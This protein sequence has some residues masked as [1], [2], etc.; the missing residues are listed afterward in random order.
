M[1]RIK[2]GGGEDGE[3]V[4][5]P[6]GWGRYTSRVASENASSWKQGVFNAG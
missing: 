1:G 5:S 6:P 4:L 3:P 2:C